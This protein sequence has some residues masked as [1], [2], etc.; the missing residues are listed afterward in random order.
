MN[1][2]ASH[3]ALAAGG[4]AV[5]TGGASGIGLAAATAL[6][7]RGLR[8]CIADRTGLDEAAARIGGDVL[9]LQTDV[10]SR[11]EVEKLAAAVAERLGPVSVL[12]NNAG[13]GGG[14]DVLSS[15]EIWSQVLG[16]NLMGVLHGVQSFVPAMIGQGRPGLVIN[17]GSKQ[18]ITQP[19]GNTAYNVSKSGVKALT[20][21]LAHTLREKTGG[22]ISA[23]LLIP[24]FTY[25]G[26]TTPRRSEFP[27]GA[28]T[29][30]QV[31]ERLFEGLARDEFYILCQDN[32]TTRAQDEKRILWAAGDLV[33]NRPAL[34]R[35]HPD[36]KEKFAAYMA[37]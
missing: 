30:E 9:A 16:V 6:A 7:A 13:I 21:G 19:P 36:W 33:E 31:V 20:E 1:E 4:V 28:W 2:L 32:E 37:E 12:M 5:I 11:D 23:H 10:S 24:G 14:G 25:T 29:P 22:R 34:S 27:A 35:W 17:T 3:P 18:G 8:V 26:M 15:P